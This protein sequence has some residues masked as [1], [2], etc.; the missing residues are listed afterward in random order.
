MAEDLEDKAAADFLEHL[1]VDEPRFCPKCSATRNKKGI[2]GRRDEEGNLRGYDVLYE[3]CGHVV[4]YE[5]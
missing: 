1:M 5:I 4:Y 3:E 2:A